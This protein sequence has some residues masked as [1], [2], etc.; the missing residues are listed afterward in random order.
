MKTLLLDPSDTVE[1]V[2]TSSNQ[3]VMP[4][5]KLAHRDIYK[6][7]DIVKMGV[8]I[9]RATETIAAGSLVDH[10]V[11]KE[12]SAPVVHRNQ[13]KDLELPDLPKRLTQFMGYVNADGSVG[14]RNYLCI[15]TSVQCVSGVMEH[16]VK[17]IKQEI[18]PCYPNVD[19]VVLLNHAYGCGVAID[20]VDAEIPKRTLRN[21]MLNPNFGRYT[22]LV[23]LGCEKLQHNIIVDGLSKRDENPVMEHDS[24]YFQSVEGDG[25]RAIIDAICYRVE[26]ALVKLNTRKRE[27]VS[28]SKLV[29]GMQCG[30][31]DS[32]SGITANPVMGLVSDLLVRAG[33][34][35]MFSET[36]ECIDA[37]PYLKRRCATN[38]VG[39]R[40]SGEFE[41][42]RRYLDRGG[43]DRAAN[44]TPGNKAGGLSSISEKA[45]GS[46]AKAGNSSIV[47]VIPPGNRLVVPGLNFLS[48]P[49]SDFICGTLQLAAGANMHLFSTGLGTPYSIYGFPVIKI[50]SSTQLYK[51][52]FDII[53]FDCG[54]MLAGRRP[55]ELA[56]E[57]LELV[58]H[59]A[60]GHATC[61]E[62]LGISND[63]VLFN[64]APVT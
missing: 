56:I 55:D 7:E 47:D 45:L 50:S 39:K 49:A 30:G 51:H 12:L 46:I 35:T 33:G 60:S 54:R 64:P 23:G 44:S 11:M 18:L 61:A 53:D 8:T 32:F 52:W 10:R 4:G 28:I 26:A 62:K 15:A 34:S 59:V 3:H 37:L 36:T 48:G 14:T 41:W 25:F 9:G 6:G 29:V 13:R 5:S 31:S 42:Y 27:P 24:L 21:I 58:V 43:V 1:V 17:R 16:A 2:L 38:D 63:I 40:L 19:G 22:F 20:A 57:L